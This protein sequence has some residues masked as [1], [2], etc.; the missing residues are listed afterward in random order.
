MLNLKDYPKRVNTK[1]NYKNMFK[2]SM[3][4]IR[5]M[6][7]MNDVAD[8]CRITVYLFIVIDFK[9]FLFREFHS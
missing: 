3:Y 7:F 1:P 5:Y 8:L 6:K 2:S 9:D 4:M